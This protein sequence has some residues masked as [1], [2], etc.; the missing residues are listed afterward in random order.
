MITLSHNPAS[1]RAVGLGNCA[2]AV[3]AQFIL[4]ALEAAGP[5]ELERRARCR[6]RYRV[7]AG[8]Q[9]LADDADEAPRRI[10]TRDMTPLGIGFVTHDPLPLGAGANLLLPASTGGA[11]MVAC[12][13]TRCREIVNGW[14]DCAVSFK[15]EKHE[16]ITM[17]CRTI[18]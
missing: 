13:V 11:D 6:V 5:L 15:E 12:N 2:L 10:Y 4:S 16:P 3:E 17:E 14:F 1:D 7:E 9:L 18:H 8:L